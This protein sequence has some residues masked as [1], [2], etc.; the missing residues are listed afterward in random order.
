MAVT[1][2]DYGGDLS[3]LYGFDPFG[4]KSNGSL[5]GGATGYGG[6]GPL[7]KWPSQSAA[8]AREPFAPLRAPNSTDLSW[9]S[10]LLNALN[11]I[12]SAQA[13]EVNPHG[14]NPQQAVPWMYP[15]PNPQVNQPNPTPPAASPSAPPS[16]SGSG[17]GDPR[18]WGTPGA[19][20]ETGPE[21]VGNLVP[22]G[23]VT[24]NRPGLPYGQSPLTP[25]SIKKK[26]SSWNT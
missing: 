6:Y 4:L 8:M 11:P 12:G 15:T 13:Q 21:T 3:D 25:V 10:R 19:A 23:A 14:D 22:A 2:F 18:L 26:P 7:S 24:T 17:Y 20:P 5:A 9:I 1:P 16:S